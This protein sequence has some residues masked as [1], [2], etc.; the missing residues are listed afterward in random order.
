MPSLG[1]G[2]KGSRG[3]VPPLRQ[4]SPIDIDSDSDSGKLTYSLEDSLEL[5]TPDRVLLAPD[6][7]PVPQFLEFKLPEWL[8][9]S[10]DCP[11]SLRTSP[12]E[13]NADLVNVQLLNRPLHPEACIN[14]LLQ[15]YEDNWGKGH[16]SVIDDHFETERLPPRIIILWKELNRLK[17]GQNLWGTAWKWC[18]R[19]AKRT[20]T[21]KDMAAVIDV[22]NT[23]PWNLP[24]DVD[25]GYVTNLNLSRFLGTAFLTDGDLL[26]MTAA[27]AERLPQGSFASSQVLGTYFPQLLDKGSSTRYLKKVFDAKRAKKLYFPLNV[28]GNHWIAVKVDFVEKT[29]SYGDSLPDGFKVPKDFEKALQ[30]SLKSTLGLTKFKSTGNTL[31]HGVQEDGYSCG[32]VTANTIEHELFQDAL[33]TPNDAVRHRLSWF[34]RLKDRWRAVASKSGGHPSDVSRT[35]PL[36]CSEDGGSSRAS[37]PPP[38]LTLPMDDEGFRNLPAS[39]FDRARVDGQNPA[40]ADERLE[41]APYLYNLPKSA[42]WLL[43]SLS[44]TDWLALPHYIHTRHTAFV[45]HIRRDLRSSPV[46]QR[47]LDLF[48][49]EMAVTFTLQGISVAL[50]WQVANQAIPGRLFHGRRSDQWEHGR[51]T[52]HRGRSSDH[53]NTAVHHG[54][55]ELE[56]RTVP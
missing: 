53:E 1:R 18:Q 6:D 35:E 19:M 34:M 52:D 46:S 16:R 12:D 7:L 15:V 36:D 32:L 27:I 14:R 33:W 47:Y 4:H 38:N 43:S 40:E 55:D 9:Q 56:E 11:C 28:N 44:S 31:V 39:L 2:N 8:S 54:L 10:K 48:K 21:K 3:S 41:T 5:S 26:F 30:D 13:P 24:T 17:K 51:S 20:R 25:K 50:T 22:L 45:Q 23:L 49:A 29:I 42:P 37:S